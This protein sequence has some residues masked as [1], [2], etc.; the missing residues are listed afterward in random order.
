MNT[1]NSDRKNSFEQRI[2]DLEAYKEKRGHVN[3][4]QSED[5]RLYNFCNHMRRARNNPEKSKT[6]INEKRIASLDALGFGWRRTS[7]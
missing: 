3:V 6:L 4:K 1:T 5:K 7:I 2:E